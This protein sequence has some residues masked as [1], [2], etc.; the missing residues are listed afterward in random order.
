MM[1]KKSV[2]ESDQ[3]LKLVKLFE[4]RV[5]WVALAE[6]ATIQHHEVAR[7]IQSETVPDTLG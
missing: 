3:P 2:Q 4:K 7:I 1:S 5:Q 6:Q